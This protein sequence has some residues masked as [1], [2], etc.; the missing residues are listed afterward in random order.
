MKPRNLPS[1]LFR[2]ETEWNFGLAT[3]LETPKGW[4]EM[5]PLLASALVFAS[6]AAHTPD[7][8]ITTFA[9][10]R[11]FR[12]SRG[13]RLPVIDYTAPDHVPRHMSGI[14][15]G[16]PLSPTATFGL[17]FFNIHRSNSRFAIDPRSNAAPRH[18][19][20]ASVG[21]TMKF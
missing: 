5:L 18:S 10:E 1:N 2:I 15:A 16:V 9:E 3:E 7:F 12:A 13:I 19:K 17:G 11:P 20:K 6:P 14:I 8:S 21:V 4:D